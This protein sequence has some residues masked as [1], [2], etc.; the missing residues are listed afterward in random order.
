MLCVDLDRFKPVND[1]HGH[2]AGDLVLLEAARRLRACA[3]EGDTVARV[4]GDEFVVVVAAPAAAGEV[5][6]LCDRLTEALAHPFELP[7]GAV[8][9][10]ASVGVA[11]CPDDAADPDRLLSQADM[12]LYEA[13]R[14]GR[15]AWRSFG[16]ALGERLARRRGLERELREAVEAEA[17][18]LGFRPR[19]RL[20]DMRLVA[21]E[22]LPRLRHPPRGAALPAELGPIAEGC[23]LDLP[24]AAWALRE[25]CRRA[26]GAAGLVVSVDVPPAALGGGG[27]A[28]RLG[29]ILDE[30]GL[31]PARLELELAE[32]GLA[33]EAGGQPLET[34][35]ALK[36]MGVR[37]TLDG[38]GAGHA[39]LNQL[40]RFPSTGSRSPGPP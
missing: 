28:D 20:G 29:R 4:G 39:S 18:E 38:F 35:R 3:R 31:Q 27:F 6:A 5:A 12:A 26:A 16:P 7:T 30:T 24:V 37:L 34:M 10:G 15:G 13:K 40:R 8:A 21:A 17:L 22:A 2:A 25:A 33:P 19:F 9:V 32:G 36:A 1:T 23:G 14:A 11:W